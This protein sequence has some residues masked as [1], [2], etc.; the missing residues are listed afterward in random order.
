MISKL[1]IFPN[2][3]VLLLSSFKDCILQPFALD[4]QS[5]KYQW[6][7]M[8]VELMVDFWALNVAVQ[9]FSLQDCSWEEQGFSLLSRL[10]SETSSVVLDDKHRTAYNLTY[11]TLSTI[12]NVD[13]SKFRRAVWNYILCLYGIRYS[14]TL[15]LPCSLL[16][17]CERVCGTEFVR[18][19]AGS[20]VMSLCVCLSRH[21]DYNY[22]EVNQLLRRDLKTF[23]KR[24]CCYPERLS[25]SDL[26]E[27]M[28]ELQYSEKVLAPF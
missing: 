4:V 17:T 22:Q 10:Y 20:F 7:D 8:C 27:A 21:D 19:W 24:A 11:N 25:G 14:S 5:E 3:L 23:I 15:F 12:P 1:F 28:K 9:I 6:D 16:G 2:Y 26:R 13:T 18:R